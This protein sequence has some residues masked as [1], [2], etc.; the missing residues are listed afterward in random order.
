M[1]ISEAMRAYLSEI[2]SEALE[3]IYKNKMELKPQKNL[4]DWDGWRKIEIR[5]TDVVG[6]FT[7]VVNWDSI[8]LQHDLGSLDGEQSKEILEKAMLVWMDAEIIALAE[9]VKS[10]STLKDM[11]AF[12]D[13]LARRLQILDYIDIK[14]VKHEIMQE[15][16]SLRG[17]RGAQARFR[18]SN[19]IKQ[20]AWDIFRENFVR[21]ASF[22][23]AK[24]LLKST[25]EF[26]KCEGK[27]ADIELKTFSNWLPEFKRRI[28]NKE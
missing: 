26:C 23:S 19:Q 22:L 5:T 17:K 25:E 21:T 4:P 2:Q 10:A 13:S 16:L 27:D 18:E 24:G 3:R 11:Y 6:A 8:E 14:E 9:Y 12:S 7:T 20:I 1:A 28:N 15:Y